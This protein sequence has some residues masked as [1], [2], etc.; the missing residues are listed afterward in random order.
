VILTF[1]ISAAFLSYIRYEKEMGYRSFIMTAAFFA[2]ALLSKEP[3]I[4]FPFLVLAWDLSRDGKVHIKRLLVLFAIIILY[5]LVRSAALGG[6]VGTLHIYQAGFIRVAEFA[7]GYIKLLVVPWPLA[8]HFKAPSFMPMDIAL[9]AAILAAVMWTVAK[10][11]RALFFLIWVFLTLLP[12]LSLAFHTNPRFAER[13]VYLPSLGFVVIMA[14]ALPLLKVP[15]KVLLIGLSSVVAAFTLLCIVSTK[16]WRND[17][18]FYEKVTRTNPDVISGYQGLANYYE[19]KGRYTEAIVYE[20]K[21]LEFAADSKLRASLHDNLGRLYGMSGN[22][23]ESIRHYEKEI[24]IIPRS[25]MAYVG[26]GNNYL[27]N[28]DNKNALK[29]YTMA[30]EIDNNNYEACYNLGTVY[31]IFG[32]YRT[33]ERY[34]H[35]V[36]KNAPEEKYAAVKGIISKR[37]PELRNIGF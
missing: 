10:D 19:S 11:G 27:L 26:I 5:L 18:A 32:D 34:Y 3:A 1:F 21:C 31:E 17:E 16:D 24:A 22:S 4:V 33:A 15:G 35:L 14:Y 36:L 25:S 30:Y 9:S 37:H 2:G 7:A 20:L 8:M 29:Y 12:S 13:F 6:T 23:G 28:R